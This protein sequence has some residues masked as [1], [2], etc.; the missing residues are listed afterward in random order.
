MRKTF[1]AGPALLPDATPDRAGSERHLSKQAGV[2][3]ASQTIKGSRVHW[4]PETIHDIGY[5]K[6]RELAEV[7]DGFLS[8]LRKP[9]LTD[10]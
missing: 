5:H 1:T 4:V 2:E 3:A 6:P 8:G 9:P 7:I 10:V